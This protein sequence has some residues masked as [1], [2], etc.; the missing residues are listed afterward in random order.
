[1][2]R[3]SRSDRMTNRI[4]WTPNR[5]KKANGVSVARF[6]PAEVNKAK[7]FHRSFPEYQETPLHILQALANSRDRR[8][9]SE[10]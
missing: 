2:D 5:M 8:A 4:A 3:T 7:D 1:M 9:V 6:G 10:R